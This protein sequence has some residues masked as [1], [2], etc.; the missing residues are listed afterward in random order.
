MDNYEWYEISGKDWDKLNESTREI[1]LTP[2]DNGKSH[3]TYAGRADV[4]K[5]YKIKT[6]RKIRTA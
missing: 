2:M 3:L 5:D 4:V 6:L 1:F